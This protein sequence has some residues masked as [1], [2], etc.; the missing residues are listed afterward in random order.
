MDSGDD[1][2]DCIYVGLLHFD[3]STSPNDAEP[4]QS[5]TTKNYDFLNGFNDGDK[6]EVQDYHEL[7]DTRDPVVDEP[8]NGNEHETSSK[9]SNAF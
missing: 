9:D 3:P 8:G 4:V 2:G 7:D 5:P 6:K 1:P